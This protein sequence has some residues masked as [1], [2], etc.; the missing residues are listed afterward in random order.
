MTDMIEKYFMER[1]STHLNVLENCQMNPDFYEEYVVNIF[2]CNDT[3][4]KAKFYMKLLNKY[5]RVKNVD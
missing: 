5:Q 4:N 3:L 1:I 2:A